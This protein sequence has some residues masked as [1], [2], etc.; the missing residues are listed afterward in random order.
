MPSHTTR[1]WG[2]P[3]TFKNESVGGRAAETL[4]GAG[5]I[6]LLGWVVAAMALDVATCCFFGPA[7]QAAPAAPEPRPLAPLLLQGPP[8]VEVRRSP[9]EHAGKTVRWYGE[10]QSASGTRVT[11]IGA[12]SSSTGAP[13]R[14]VVEYGPGA[15]PPAA[16]GLVSGKVAGS[17]MVDVSTSGPGSGSFSFALVPLL[18]EATFE[19]LAQPVIC[20]V[21][22]DGKPV[23][24]AGPAAPAP[25]VARTAPAAPVTPTAPA[26]R[27]APAAPIAPAVPAPS[28]VLPGSVAPGTVANPAVSA[29]V[30]QPKGAG[31]QEVAEGWTVLFRSCDP[32]NWNKDANKGSVDFAVPLADAPAGIQF[33]KMAIV[34]GG[35]VIIPMTNDHLRMMGP[36]G[37]GNYCWDG[38][39]AFSLGAYHLGIYDKTVRLPYPQV[40][41]T[42]G[43]FAGGSWENYSGWGFGSH[44]GTDDK[45]CC[46]WGGKEIPSTVFEIAVKTIPL[47]EAERPLVLAVG[48]ATDAPFVS[49]SSIRTSRSGVPGAST[50]RSSANDPNPPRER[51]FEALRLL[52]KPDGSGSSYGRQVPKE[53]SS[54]DDAAV[55]QFVRDLSAIIRGKGLEDSL[56]EGA[57]MA[58]ERGPEI[59]FTYIA[60]FKNSVP[61]EQVRA[62]LGPENFIENDARAA[63]SNAGPDPFTHGPNEH[64]RA[65]RWYHYGW[66]LF[67][68]LDGKVVQIK[69]ELWKLIPATAK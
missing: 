51:E 49:G 13:Y 67:G 44:V 43:I 28:A 36:L 34:G 9:L 26:V 66:L 7:A 18:V 11:Y 52:G 3:H 4:G 39:G 14:F 60:S 41:G 10:F 59:R 50:A 38:R 8:F 20:P 29:P 55:S 57:Q 30:L 19:P 45:Q 40:K 12:K 27:T 63:A 58:A 47:T 1:Q 15:L 17:E 32:A 16:T 56:R 48:A 25:P 2:R 21:L 68:E 61:M 23:V 37:T 24:P 69:A 46:A 62:A 42:V 5:L 35:A 6:A 54:M 65:E 53:R 33:L 31:G 64:K 22:D